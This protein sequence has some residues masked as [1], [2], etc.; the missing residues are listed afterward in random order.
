MPKL[1][2]ARDL[3]EAS[4]AAG[5]ARASFDVTITVCSG[6]SCLAAR[7]ED[8]ADALT[9]ELTAQGLQ[10]RVALRRTGCFGFCERGPVVLIQPREICYLGVR[11]GDAADIVSQTICRGRLVERLLFEDAGGKRVAVMEQIPFYQHQ[12]RMLLQA[13]TLVD[14]TRLED[15][16]AN[17]GYSALARVLFEL[18]PRAVIE[19]IIRSG[20]RGRGGGGFSTGVK[21]RTCS[22]AAGD[23][24]YVIVNADEGD[25]GAYMDRSLL[26]GNPHSIL[27]GVI[28]GARAIG[29]SEGFIY[30]RQEY[31]LALKNTELALDQAREYGLLG[32]DILG[33][34][35][36]F[37]V[38]IH[39]GAGA[40]V[41]GE[42]TALISAI[43]GDVDQPRPKYVHTSESGL[44][45]K[46]TVINNVETW[47]N[48]PHII[49]NGPSWFRNMGTRHS[50]GTKI[51][52]LEGKVKHSGL[53][54]VPM[55]TSLRQIIFDIGGGIKGG[56]R[57]KAV[58][59]G[60]PSGGV[61]PES[62][63]DLPVDFDVLARHG[64][65]MGSGGMIVMDEDACIVDVTRNCV[66]FLAHESCGQCVPCREGLRL[67]LKTLNA[68]VSG[69][70]VAADLDLLEE[71]CELLESASMCALGQSA[72]TPVRSA[73]RHFRPEF[74]AHVFDNTCPALVCPELMIYR[75]DHDRCTGCS[76]CLS[77]CPTD[78][79]VGHAKEPLSID[80]DRCIKCGACL[81][82]CPD[83]I[84]AVLLI[85]GRPGSRPVARH[86]QP[87]KEEK[88]HEH[89]IA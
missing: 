38:T 23:T 62:L 3:I 77:R 25:P 17:G 40:F 54:E 71:L 41:S 64:F 60:G 72:S 78:A 50:K 39:H 10:H 88:H 37:D 70:G 73:L 29:A 14:P 69:R 11:P 76:L 34:G 58:Q 63:L 42:S 28:I 57:F 89:L 79:I 21:W 35:L 12:R 81:E 80:Q 46:P 44:R 52:S 59:T 75:I 19:T 20:L 8:L 6:T 45:G 56:K 68:V 33:S 67:M 48:V 51:F 16:L 22:D 65:M 2:S 49:N 82:A 13:N 27:E 31:P 83:K 61:L 15:Y 32:Q 84:N 86:L 18:E 85:S 36:D 1:R 30:L 9:H 4:R 26:E 53:V 24:R 74:E 7:S 87:S 5:A 55:G 43:E 66:D 47:A